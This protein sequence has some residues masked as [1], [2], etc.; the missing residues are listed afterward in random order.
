MA[1]LVQPR[2]ALKMLQPFW[3][4][5]VEA[6]HLKESE[7]RE[8]RWKKGYLTLTCQTLWSI[9]YEPGPLPNSSASPPMYSFHLANSKAQTE[10]EKRPAPTRY[11]RQVEAT[12]KSWSLVLEPPLKQS[13]L[14][15]G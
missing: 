9:S 14:E 11:R 5:S 6:Q 12:R 15:G 1:E 10:R 3:M 13:V 7:G 4:V 2:M 8:S